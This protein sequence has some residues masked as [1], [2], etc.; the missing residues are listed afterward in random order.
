MGGGRERVTDCGTAKGRARCQEADRGTYSQTDSG[1]LAR[2][3][4][5]PLLIRLS[6]GLEVRVM[7]F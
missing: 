3:I 2:V 7:V 6:E 4:A 5:F 1:S